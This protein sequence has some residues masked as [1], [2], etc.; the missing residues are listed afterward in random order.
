MTMFEENV[1]KL[2][3]RAEINDL[4]VTY[5][6][7]LDTKDWNALA[8]LFTD[9]GHIGLPFGKLE[10]KDM[11]RAAAAVLRPFEATQHL[12]TNIGISIDDD[13]GRTSHYFQAVHLPTAAD[14]DVHSVIGGRYNNIYRRTTNGWKLVNVDI[15]FV[16]SSGIP[17]DP[18]D[19]IG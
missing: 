7:C 11:A 19:P 10:K 17:L 2:L 8:D 1:Q 15:S 4:L 3:D 13:T 5:A 12:Y 16:W 6:H 9:D 14:Q 18:G